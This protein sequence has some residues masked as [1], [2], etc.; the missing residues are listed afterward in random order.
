M[1]HTDAVLILESRIEELAKKKGVSMAQIGIAWELA[2]PHVTAPII[3]TPKFEYLKDT[4]GTTHLKFRYHFADKFISQ[5]QCVLS[6]QR[7]KLDILRIR[8]SRLLF[9]ATHNIGVFCTG[10]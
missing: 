7:R 1:G 9:M 5:R 4:I 10:M 2:K 3:G 6:L 8:I